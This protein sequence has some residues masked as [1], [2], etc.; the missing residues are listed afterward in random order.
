[1][2]CFQAE[3]AL[4]GTIPMMKR[5]RDWSFKTKVISVLSGLAVGVAA[6]GGIT[7]LTLQ[8][9]AIG[10][11]SYQQ[12]V[13]SK[14]LLADVLPPPAYLI[15]YQ[16]T[17]YELAAKPNADID[18][19]AAK[20]EKLRG[21]YAA[22]EAFWGE[23][24]ASDELR[25]ALAASDTTTDELF[26]LAENELVPLVRQGKG[27]EAVQLVT[28]KIE[29]AYGAHRAGVDEVV[30]IAV[31]QFN[32]ADVNAKNLVDARRA[33][34]FSV[35]LIVLLIAIAA[36]P[37][38]VRSTLPPVR[39][40][41]RLAE[42]LAAGKLSHE[43]E[44]RAG[45]DDVT[46]AAASLQGAVKDL[47]QEMHSMGEHATHLASTADELSTTANML[48]T[49]DGGGAVG[50]VATAVHELNSSINELS[51]TTVVVSGTA[52]Q[53]V[54]LAHE[55]RFNIEAL[56]RS[57]QAIADVVGMISD[58]AEQTNLL[59]L[60]ATIEAARAGESGKG[61]AVVAGE[62]KELANQTASATQD[63]RTKI[64][65]IQ[66]DVTKA[67]AAVASVAE[68]VSD[69]S[70]SQ[71]AVAATIEEQSAVVSS[72]AREAEDAASA[73]SQT[74]SAA[75]DLA[76]RSIDIKAMVDRFDI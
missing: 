21:E 25:A 12:I 67:M 46:S 38:L 34:L 26:R 54:E 44:L 47:R 1:L 14:D 48:A 16:L 42:A 28:T 73:A 5:F 40:M 43:E 35:L 63:I 7:M 11:T 41:A 72:I 17:A 37:L 9:V 49:S 52:E 56:G 50:H 8:Q 20:L 13:D 15:E 4:F 74:G 32:E 33:V 23:Y 19:L 69:I 71:A 64:A 24:Q 68:V 31:T 18:T 75:R 2:S 3:T 22:R 70:H 57:S 27:A 29:N 59:A 62:V 39:A 65:A 45:H 61:F 10:S 66:S 53:A 51:R 58:V 36:I 55:A 76:K 30:K 6:A 60:N